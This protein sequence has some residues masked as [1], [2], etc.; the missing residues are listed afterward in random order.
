[1]KHVVITGGTRGIGLGLV[2]GFLRK[3]CRVTFTGT[4]DRSV[5]N[6]SVQLNDLFH[7]RD[8]KGVVCDVRNYDHL[9]KLWEFTTGLYGDVNIWIN[10][11]GITNDQ[12][13]FNTI[14]PEITDEIISINLTSAMK[15]TSLVYNNM[16]KTGKP[17]YI[18]NMGGLGSDGRIVKGLTPYG[19]SKRAIQHFVKSFSKETEGSPVRT[20]LIIP[21]MVLTDMLLDPIRNEAGDTRQ[22]RKVCN[23]LA[24]KVEDVTPVL[25]SKILEN[26]SNGAVISYTA[27]WKMMIKVPWRLLTGRDIVGPSL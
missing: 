8:F 20:G 18:Y 12:A 26:D 7:N 2:E 4:S 1:M 16:L 19:V 22:L 21:G 6:A 10:N 23:M 17:G 27:A 14:D 25:V 13:D 5:N 15:A 9:V 11:A 24:D 3:G